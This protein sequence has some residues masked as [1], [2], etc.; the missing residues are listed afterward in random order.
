MTDSAVA[1][2]V[3]AERR[4]RHVPSPPTVTR[5]YLACYAEQ[6]APACEG[7]VMPR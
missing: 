2:D 4:A 5:G 3:M 6:V 7:A 1:E